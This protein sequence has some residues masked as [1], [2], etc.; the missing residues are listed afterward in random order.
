[1]TESTTYAFLRARGI[2]PMAR[3]PSGMLNH[4]AFDKYCEE[5]ARAAGMQPAVTDEVDVAP[6][7]S[8]A[9]VVRWSNGRGT[10]A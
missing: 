5:Q 4:E 6:D 9:R 10:A 1:M 7:G 3:H 2:D 8:L